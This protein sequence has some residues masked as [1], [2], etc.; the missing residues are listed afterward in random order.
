[1]S[2]AG[3]GP[4]IAAV[5]ISGYCNARTLRTSSTLICGLGSGNFKPWNENSRC[6]T[7]VFIARLPIVVVAAAVSLLAIRRTANGQI[8]E[9]RTRLGC[10][11]SRGIEQIHCGLCRRH[12]THLLFR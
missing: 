8:V 7:V 12:Q 4:V 6:I 9:T 5:A 10:W 1:M 11:F 3:S 2:P